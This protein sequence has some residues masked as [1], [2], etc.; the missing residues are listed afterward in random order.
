ME[1]IEHFLGF[2][3]DN[4]LHLNVWHLLL[5]I[6]LIKLFYEKVYKLGRGL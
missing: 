3:E 5:L 6:I 1:I 2:C 4:H